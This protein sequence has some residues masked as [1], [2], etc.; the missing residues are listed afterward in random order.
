MRTLI[1]VAAI[2]LVGVTAGSQ[3]P[4]TIHVF[5]FMSGLQTPIAFV[6]DPTDRAVFY[7]VEQAGRIRA[8]RNRA[9]AETLVDLRGAITSGGERGLLGLAFAPDFASSGRFF[10]NFTNLDGD[11]VISRVR[12]GSGGV[13]DIAN[14]FDLR[15][16]E[17]GPG[18][19]AQPF[20][21]H[22]GG[23]LAFGPDGFLY[24]GLGDGGS[25]NDPDHRAQNMST[26][27]G[28]MLRIDVNVPDGHAIGYVIPGNNPFISAA[29]PVRREIWSLG[30]RNPWRYSFDVGPDGTGALVIGDVGQGSFEEIDYE[31]AGRG[32]RNYGWR[33]REGKHDTNIMPNL[34]PVS[35]P[36][37]DPIHE[38]GRSEG[39]SVTGG[40]VYRGRSLPAQYRGR[41]FFA[42]FPRG[43]VWSLGLTLAGGEATV[44]G[45]IEHTAELGG[46][47]V[48]GNISSFGTDQDGEL[49]IVS[50]SR[51]VVLRL[52]GVPP[53]P[54]NLHIIR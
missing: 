13:G 39:T 34:P 32:G 33:N 11:T 19:I 53:T 22:N 9:F 20:S 41:Y 37:I 31:P 30:L 5:P 18:I 48:L 28:K 2:M 8:V 46:T 49:F 35:Q 10:I 25:G 27:L 24:I 6:A 7:A 15:F 45:I 29:P 40:I 4:T 44:S 3:S 51:G 1:T 52:A 14:R 47:S 50:Y 12:R 54:Q 38:Y 36:L 43:R 23:H 17:G 21:N 16:D 26:L 42:D